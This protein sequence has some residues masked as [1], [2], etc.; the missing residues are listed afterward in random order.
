MIYTCNPARLSAIINK[1]AIAR[2]SRRTVSR[3]PGRCVPSASP[4]DDLLIEVDPNS[5]YK[6]SS[7]FYD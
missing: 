1:A 6:T 5:I 7:P 4:H 2:K 3:P